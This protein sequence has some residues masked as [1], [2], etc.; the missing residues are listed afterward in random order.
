MVHEPEQSD[1]QVPFDEDVHG[2]EDATLGGY[3]RLHNRPPAFEGPDGSPYT[4]SIEVEKTPDLA[5]PYA[6]FLIFPRWAD[7]GV[8]IVGHVESAILWKG[9]SSED[10][11]REA[12]TTSLDRVKSWLDE[13]VLRAGR[14]D[15]LEAGGASYPPGGGSAGDA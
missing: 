5:A 6:G 7:T 9:R 15:A 3:F 10:V 12:G 2:S 13:A 11:L 14:D 4:V 8:G 1:A